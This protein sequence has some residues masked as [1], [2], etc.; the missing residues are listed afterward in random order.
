MPHIVIG[1]ETVFSLFGLPVTNTLL[2]SWV[3]V[4]AI[5]IA[6]QA[7]ARKMS[8]VPKGFQNAVEAVIEALIEFMEGTFHSESKAVQYL[9]YV[10]TFFIM[11]VISNW[12]GI[13]PG[14][15][16]VGFRE[17]ADGV[18][19][20]LPIF[21]SPASD[22]NF[23]LALAIVSIIAINIFGVAA[24]GFGRHLSRF[25]NFSSPINFFV[26]ILELVGEAAKLI[27]LAFRLFG[28]VFAGEVL[29]I[30]VGFLAPFIAPVPFLILELFVGV[31]QALIFAALTMVFISIAVEEHG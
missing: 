17:S 29:L 11:I 27:S 9:P 2:L 25:F 12:S 14:V 6:V 30:I 15:G 3:V 23:T 8:L 10:A 1:A 5:I 26:G 16:S 18:S 31:I 20:L 7:M 13:L 22:L 19:A 24:V 4:L 21:R 28:N